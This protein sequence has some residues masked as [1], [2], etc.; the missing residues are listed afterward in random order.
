MQPL[1]PFSVAH[2]CY[3]LDILFLLFKISYWHFLSS[4]G[5][6]GIIISV[7]PQ[8]YSVS[9]IIVLRCRIVHFTQLSLFPSEYYIYY[10]LSFYLAILFRIGNGDILVLPAACW[11]SSLIFYYGYVWWILFYY[12][13]LDYG[14]FLLCFVYQE[15]KNIGWVLFY[16]W[17]EVGR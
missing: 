12:S 9:T 5:N 15:F 1:S 16:L 3:C 10:F 13:L 7:Y 2:I 14:N 17:T 6:S 4:Q 8:C 11:K